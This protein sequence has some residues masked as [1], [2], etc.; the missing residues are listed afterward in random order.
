MQE[1][2]AKPGGMSIE[3]RLR[4][5]LEAAF[6]PTLLAIENDSARHAGHAGA[7]HHAR[8]PG[9]VTGETHFN[10]TIESAAFAGKS[11]L[12]RQRMVFAVLAEDMAGPVHALSL[13]T[14]APAG[15]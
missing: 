5:K 8:G 15:N 11:R 2:R 9:V 4:A 10:V 13:T 6:T 1:S 12:E 7:A 14:R 3:Q